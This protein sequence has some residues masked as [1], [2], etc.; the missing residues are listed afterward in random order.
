MTSD[1]RQIF[2]IYDGRA[3][4]RLVRESGPDGSVVEH[5]RR[6]DMTE[7]ER[8]Y[9]AGKIPLG[10]CEAGDQFRSYFD[11]GCLGPRYGGQPLEV[12]STGGLKVSD[13]P[14]DMMAREMVRQ[15][16]V[17]LGQ[18]RGKKSVV[19]DVIWHIVGAGDDLTSY[20]NRSTWCNRPLTTESIRRILIEGL[21]RLALHWGAMTFDEIESGAAARTRSNTVEIIAKMAEIQSNILKKRGDK[22]GSLALRRFAAEIK[23]NL[24]AK[25]TE[26]KDTPCT[27]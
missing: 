16:M 14:G 13:V 15:V 23:K 19:A 5:A 7:H 18:K 20:A 4:V 2:T 27:E 6:V 10:L 9:W 11:R 21:E 22:N 17:I 12:R 26:S 24:G 25:T 8:L 1:D 3:R